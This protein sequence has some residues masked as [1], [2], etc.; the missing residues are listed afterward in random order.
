VGPS[1]LFDPCTPR[2]EMRLS[3]AEESGVGGVVYRVEPV[4]HGVGPFDLFDPCT[5]RFEMRLSL[6]PKKV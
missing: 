1:D 4:S 2:F 6:E 5:P 3:L